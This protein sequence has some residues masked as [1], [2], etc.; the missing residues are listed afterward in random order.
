MIVA[1]TVYDNGQKNDEPCHRMPKAQKYETKEP[2]SLKKTYLIHFIS[3]QSDMK[4]Q[5][6]LQI[7]TRKSISAAMQESI[8]SDMD[9]QR[10]LK[11]ACASAQS[12]QRLRCRLKK[13][14]LLGYPKYA[15]DNSDQTARMRRLIRI[16]AGRICSKVPVLTWWLIYRI[17]CNKEI[18]D[19]I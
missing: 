5:K 12:D 17:T 14:C 19:I 16:F 10:K 4:H 1:L 11:S 7:I 15:S 3:L 2:I 9:A 13:L 8:L 18:N 6:L